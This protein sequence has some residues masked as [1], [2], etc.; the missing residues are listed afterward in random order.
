[1]TA[2]LIHVTVN[3]KGL[4]GELQ[5]SLQ[6]TICLVANGLSAPTDADP[7]DIALPIDI[8]SIFAK[9]E[10]NRETF[11]ERYQEWILSAGFRDAI[12]SLGAFLESANRVLSIWDLMKK[13]DANSPVTVGDWKSVFLD[14]GNRFHRLGLPDKIE[15]LCGNRGFNV[16]LDLKMQVLSIN[17]A[18]NC[19]VHRKGV[20]SDRDSN[21]ADG[22]RVE[23]RR[24]KVFLED[25]DGERDLVLGQRV[26]K[27]SVVAVRFENEEKLFGIGE[28]LAFTVEQI[29]GIIWCLFIFGST[30]VE[31]IGKFGEVNGFLTP[32]VNSVG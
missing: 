5:R 4:I 31:E 9:L 29:S 24:M 8:Q 19:C 10:W 2:H 16:P 28:S 12:E 11:H 20:V 17:I 18:R 1:M 3:L 23:W 22:L 14:S 26:E 27:G 6:Q 21:T 32:A 13:Q 7:N 30:V 15:S 25:E